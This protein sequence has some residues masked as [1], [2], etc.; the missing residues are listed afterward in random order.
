MWHGNNVAPVVGANIK[1]DWGSLSP[2]V[3]F[4]PHGGRL[5]LV[6]FN[7]I[8]IGI[9]SGFTIVSAAR[10]RLCARGVFFF[11]HLYRC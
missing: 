3:D 9:R 5:H 6:R 7:C 4:V 8:E 11:L 10:R 1:I 2:G